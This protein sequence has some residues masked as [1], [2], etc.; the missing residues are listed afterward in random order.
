MYSI[1]INDEEYMD[2]RDMQKSVTGRREDRFMMENAM[3]AGRAGTGNPAYQAFDGTSGLLK[4]LFLM[5]SI[6]FL[7]IVVLYT[8]VLTMKLI[9]IQKITVD[10]LVAIWLCLYRCWYSFQ[11]K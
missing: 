5:D 9:S 4:E 1:T 6:V 7:H 2:V 8:T 10:I 11:S 3:S